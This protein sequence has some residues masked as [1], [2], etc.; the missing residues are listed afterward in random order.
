MD[1][2]PR[3]HLVASDDLVARRILRV[4]EPE[5][6]AGR[7][8]QGEKRQR[9]PA[10]VYIL[11]GLLNCRRC[12]KPLH[13]QAGGGN[14]RRHVCWTRL[15]RTGGCDQP[16]VKADVLEA[17]L[18]A[19]MT[20]IKLPQSWQ[21]EVIGYMLDEEG[22]EVIMAQRPL[23]QEHFDHIC[24]LYQREEITRQLYLKEWQAFER[25]L[26]ALSLDKRTDLNLGQARMLLSDFTTLWTQLSE[27]ERKE[28]TQV[29]LRTTEVEN[30]QIID[31]Q[32]YEPFADLFTPDPL[33]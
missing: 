32:W 30:Q 8:E 4:V 10:R 15:Q 1:D 31:W 6:R 9:S 18:Y 20:R 16:S 14:A 23:L 33:R 12:G 22:L 11:Q 28:I 3:E 19:Q 29:L 5:E 25:G 17:E 2:E 24:G 27:L 7:E 26:A 21:E 13:C